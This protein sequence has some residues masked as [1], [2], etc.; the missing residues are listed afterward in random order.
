LVTFL[1]RTGTFEWYM[2]WCGSKNRYQNNIMCLKDIELRAQNRK[3]QLRF[4]GQHN[5]GDLYD[6]LMSTRVFT[7][8]M[9]NMYKSSENHEE[10]GHGLD[11]DLLNISC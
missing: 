2:V 1:S 6:H 4:N 9:H 11:L 5:W 10:C 3:N 8:I 7:L